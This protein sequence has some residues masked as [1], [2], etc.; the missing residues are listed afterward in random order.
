MNDTAGGRPVIFLV[1]RRE[2]M[3]RLRSRV[4]IFGTVAIIALIAAG[5]LVVSLLTGRTSAYDVAFNGA[6]QSLEATFETYAAALGA[7]VVVSEVADASAGQDEITAGTLDVLV[8]GTSTSA[9][10]VVKSTL[11]ASVGAA[12]DAAVLDARLV[13]AGLPQD[14][15][16]HALAGAHVTTQ[17]L[18]PTTLGRTQDQLAALVVGI[19][20]YVSLALYGTFVA[21][22]V[23]EEKATRI[24]EILLATVPPSR[25]LAG[26]VVGIGLVGLLQLLLIGTV[27][28]VLINLTNVV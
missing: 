22:G 2:I 23:V 28:L 7:S 16:A 26:K 19:V 9:T 21:Q 8:T 15:V 18:Q 3:M 25:L 27:A 12:L 20:L 1:A 13:A 14:T 17:V 5:I 6:T 4:L 11:P 10:A 24:I